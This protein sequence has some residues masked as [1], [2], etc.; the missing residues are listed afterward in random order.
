[1]SMASSSSTAERRDLQSKDRRA[2][3]SYAA[4]RRIFNKKL[5]AKEQ[6]KKILEELLEGYQY[7]TKTVLE[8][9]LQE[10]SAL[11][12]FSANME[13]TASTVANL[14]QSV[15]LLGATVAKHKLET[16]CMEERIQK[17]EGSIIEINNPNKKKGKVKH[18]NTIARKKTSSVIAPS[19]K[20]TTTTSSRKEEVSTTRREMPDW[21]IQMCGGHH[22]ES[23]L[24]GSSS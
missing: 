11:R 5:R 10:L 8:P 18:N 14:F 23:D 22:P 1:V 6:E 24:S 17:V 20:G 21:V 9:L 15:C 12:Q 2:W 19:P 13:T 3:N 16:Y 7:V 4:Q